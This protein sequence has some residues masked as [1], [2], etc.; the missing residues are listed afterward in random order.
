MLKQ[1]AKIVL[2]CLD[3]TSQLETVVNLIEPAL[4][5]NQRRPRVMCSPFARASAFGHLAATA[6][7]RSLLPWL[8]VEEG[9]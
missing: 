4:R 8:V 7:I 5:Q 2:I 6:T 3:P 1:I 9:F